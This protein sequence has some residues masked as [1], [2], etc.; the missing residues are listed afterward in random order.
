MILFS[1]YQSTDR[2]IKKNLSVYSRE[3]MYSNKNNQKEKE[4]K[5]DRV[6]LTN[7]LIEEIVSSEFFSLYSEE[8]KKETIRLLKELK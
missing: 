8:E 5:T 3:K 1:Y 7:N 2:Y 4:N 6:E